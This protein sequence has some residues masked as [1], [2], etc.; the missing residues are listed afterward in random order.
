MD[1]HGLI[2]YLVDLDERDGCVAVVP[3][4]FCALPEAV[5]LDMTAWV[6][7]EGVSG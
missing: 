6:V 7:L 2:C 1:L 3:P 5:S 4:R